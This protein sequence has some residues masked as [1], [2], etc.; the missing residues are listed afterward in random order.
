[1]NEFAVQMLFSPQN[2]PLWLLDRTL[3]TSRRRTAADLLDALR[4]SLSG[5]A[6]AYFLTTGVRGTGKSHVLAYV[7]K[8]L[9]KEGHA[10]V[11]RLSEEER[12]I[13]TAFDFV[14][15]LLRAAGCSRED[16]RRRIAAPEAAARFEQALGLFRETTREAPTLI[17]VENFAA[18][19]A[20][21][22]EELAAGIRA[23]L[24]NH[25]FVSVLASSIGLFAG[26]SHPDHPF[27]GFFT[28]VP[29][30]K[31]LQIEAQ[32][33]LALLADVEG[34]S[35]LAARLR[36]ERGMRRVNAAYDLTGGNHRLLAMLARFL[37][38]DGLNEL[39]QPFVEMVDRE[40]TPYFQQRLDKLSA[41]QN[42]I[43]SAIA[44]HYGSTV[45]VKEVAQDT[46][47]TSQ[48]VS[49]QLHDLLHGGY[50]YRA[51]KGRESG[52]ELAEPLLRLVLDLK[53]GRGRF[54][55][56]IVDLLRAWYERGELALLKAAAPET[57]RQYYEAALA[58]SG[59]PRGDFATGEMRALVLSDEGET[60]AKT[61]V[62]DLGRY[63]EEGNYAAALLEAERILERE[64]EN[65]KAWLAKVLANWQLDRFEDTLRAVTE[66]LD[67]FDRSSEK[68][69]PHDIAFLLATKA[70]TL[71]RLER[72]KEA[73]TGYDEVV[74]RF[75]GAEELFLR[76]IVAEVLLNKGVALGQLGRPEGA[77]A[78][79]DEVV[80]R[81]GESA[82]LSLREA[83]A[84][85]LVNK[86]A[87]L[88][89]L[90][91]P[92]E[93]VGAYDTAVSRFGGA[94]ELSLREQVAKALVNKGVAFGELG[95]REEALPVWDEAVSRFGCAEELSLREAAGEA[96]VNKGI[97]LRQ[98]G[99]P[100]EA[101]AAC[102]AVISRLG[103]AE[104]PSLRKQVAKALFCKAASLDQL[105]RLEEV[106][107]VCD[108]LVLRFGGAEELSVR[109]L[110][111]RALVNKGIALRQL[112][113]LEEALAAWDEVVSR[114]EAA[115][116]LSLRELVA[117]ALVN[118]GIALRQ[119]ARLE[120]ALV[121]WD[122]V[123][124]RFGD[125]KEPDL[126]E[127]AGIALACRCAGL[128]GT[129]VEDEKA[130]RALAESYAEK[131]DVL[132]NGLVT[133]VHGNLP[134][135]KREAERLDRAEEALVS[136]FGG[137]E[138]LGMPVK[139]FHAARRYILGDEAAVLELPLELR[140]LVL[141]EIDPKAAKAL[142]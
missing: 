17:L 73:L 77:L 2:C 135:S 68:S 31:L 103:G 50:V 13:V 86:G 108:G 129:S 54:L 109:E 65:S 58:M 95:R 84:G 137:D 140:R 114:V 30:T 35:E 111:A 80:S 127:V 93:E 117:Q 115:E 70:A 61:Q 97:T 92:E 46:F 25:P 41:Q 29:L 139:M 27:Y 88:G 34:D 33:Y 47:L 56:I 120:E 130:L 118:K 131:S 16:L 81:F 9:I 74:S 8:T 122:E 45:T 125:A 37:T 90:R 134:R 76:E 15:A 39:V 141:K 26:S 133:W 89:Q 85:A 82:E 99:R 48:G 1:V 6:S 42:K 66:A 49:R 36:E 57:A 112:G 126:R 124:S 38:V 69:A 53:E 100:E 64:P 75:G 138:K 21:A 128:I 83:V 12:G 98:L 78:A 59:I 44:A 18:M 40:L 22:H 7:Q 23:F 11:F 116:E 72:P 121:A 91:R 52:Y 4:A 104:E 62:S 19:L 87:A 51:P 71:A 136:V 10:S 113:R 20:N 96:L 119:L 5:G 24:Q 142:E 107:G 3:T 105:G 94:E 28:M 55:P 43:L 106:L 14:V 60:T 110:V 32:E 101:L 132:Y 79:C 102:D 123:V 63:L 67:R